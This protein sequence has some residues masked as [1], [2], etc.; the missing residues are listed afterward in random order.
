MSG[1]CRR[2]ERGLAMAALL[3]A[4]SVMAIML[5]AVLPVWQTWVR[6]E[7]EAELVFR[8]EQYARAISLFKRKYGNSNPPSIDILLK[9]RFLRRKYKDP[10]TGDDFAVITPTTPLPGQS[11]PPELQGRA[12]ASGRGST[13]STSRS[14]SSSSSSSSSA[15]S[16]DRTSLRTSSSLFA[17]REQ[18]RTTASRSGGSGGR[19]ATQGGSS[20]GIMG[21]MS[22]STDKSFRLY[23]GADHYNEWIFVATAASARAG[24]PSAAPAPGPEPQLG[25]G[26]GRGATQGSRGG[27]GTLR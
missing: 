20:T 5:S 14:S 18:S 13:S 15:A 8:G 3:V 23:K 21:V 10:I 7:R 6:R 17:A 16:S 4:M 19:G 24:G 1:R 9:E 27:R 26:S 2:G 11:L 12:T 22:K 25:T